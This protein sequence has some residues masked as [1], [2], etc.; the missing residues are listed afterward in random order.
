M[1]AGDHVDMTPSDP[2][3]WIVAFAMLAFAL[4]GGLAGRVTLRGGVIIDSETS[5][6]TFWLFIGGCAMVGLTL[7]LRVM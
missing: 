3:N 6:R 1:I 2:L 5:P 4:F 7:L